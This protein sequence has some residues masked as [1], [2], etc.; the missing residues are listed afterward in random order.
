[1][2]PLLKIKF[3]IFKSYSLTENNSLIEFKMV[4]ITGLEPATSTMSR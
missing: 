1:M 2:I 3:E 4:G